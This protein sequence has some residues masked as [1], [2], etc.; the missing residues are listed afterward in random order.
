VTIIDHIT[1]KHV[2]SLPPPPQPIFRNAE[3]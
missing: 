3:N 2:A 1:P